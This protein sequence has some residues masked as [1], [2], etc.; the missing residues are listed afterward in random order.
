MVLQTVLKAVFG[1]RNERVLKEIRPLVGR[2]GEL[3]PRFQAMSADELRVLTPAFRERLKQ[4]EALDALLPEAFA[5]VREAARRTLGQ[6]PFDVQMLGGIVLHQGKIAEM[7]TGEGK[8]LTACAPAFL[9]ALPARGVFIVTVNDYLARRDRDWMAPV[10]GALGM[11][12]GAIQAHMSPADRHPQYACDLTFG[13]NSEFGF[14]YLRDNMKSRREDQVQKHLHYAIVDEVDSI[15]IDEARTPLIISGMPETSTQL[16]YAADRVARDLQ[17]GPD[18]EVKEKERTCLLTEEGIEHAQ[19]LAGVESFYDGAHMEWPHHLEQSLRAHYVYKLDKDYVVHNGEQGPEIVIVDE[20]TGRLMPGRRWSDG[21]HQAIE[22]KEKLRIREELQTLA[23][24]TYQNYFRLFTKLAGMTG[25]A[26]TEAA[27]FHKIYHLDVITVPTNRPVVREDAD[28]LIY[29]TAKEKW[30]ALADEIARANA[31]GQP[32]LVGTTSI[33]T[34]EHLSGILSRRGIKHNVL[35]AK[36]HAR[37]A[38]IVQHAGRKGSVTVATNMAGRGTDIQLGGNVDALARQRLAEEGFPPTA[39]TPP[40]PAHVERVTADIKQQVEREKAEVIGLGGL[41]VIGTERHEARRIDNQL[42]GRGGRQGDP[43]RTCFYLSLEDDLMRIFAREWVSKLL[44]R[45]GM[46]E[47]QEIQSGM[48][49]R[50]IEKAQKRV[51]ARN[52]EI[53][54]NLLEYD[55]VMDTQRKTIYGKRQEVLEGHDLKPVIWEMITEIVNGIVSTRTAEGGKPDIEG[56]TQELGAKFATPFAAADFAGLSEPEALS[57]H[58][59]EKL[60]K[61]YAEREQQLGAERMRM[62][63]RFLLLNTIDARWK[64]HLR[65]MDHL[66]SG[67]GL[68]GYAQV[69]PK[70]EYKREGYDKFQMLLST[71]AEEVT[72]LLFRVQVKAEDEQRLEDR[73]Q[74]RATSAPTLGS[75]TGPAPVTAPRMA[76][77]TAGAALAAMQR[78]RERAAANAG[79]QGPPKPIVRNNQKVGRNDPCPCG[80]GKKYKHC[81]FPKYGQ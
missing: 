76:T 69:D 50:G 71:V 24:I 34:S 42:R 68:R 3:E 55:E 47:G 33:E 40:E 45:L 77:G 67:I 62:V 29:R 20:F 17:A 18:F 39:E 16:Y 1:D 72:A 58:A 46:T 66:K 44:E 81:C 43:G 6:R 52:F 23:T 28:D 37:E 49:S 79:H 48:V 11:T 26:M 32:M 21:L 8:T 27:E 7:A 70:V 80:S 53:R 63:E 10:Y 25:T 51:E 78:G 57:G 59:L 19:K 54:K 65:A 60:E 73:W 22:A 4:G 64:D 31:T 2:I 61:H 38:E 75:S 56:L 74:A 12:A 35:N 14:D 15:L 36:Q 41:Y 5:A 13:T 9:N 30:K